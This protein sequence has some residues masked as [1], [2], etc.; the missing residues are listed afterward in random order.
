MLLAGDVRSLI[1]TD[2]AQPMLDILDSK[3]SEA[4]D[5]RNWTTVVADHRTCRL[6]HRV[7]I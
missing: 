1:C 6:I 2:I 4:Y 5:F 7:W 3:L